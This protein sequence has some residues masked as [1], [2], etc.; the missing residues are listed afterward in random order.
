[1]KGPGKDYIQYFGANYIRKVGTMLNCTLPVTW[2]VHIRSA[3][4]VKM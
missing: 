2:R 4:H 1:M 3:E